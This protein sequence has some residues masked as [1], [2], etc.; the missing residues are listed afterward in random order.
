MVNSACRMAG[1]GGQEFKERDKTGNV[2]Y[3]NNKHMQHLRKNFR[4]RF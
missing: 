4:A 1:L 3:V 2:S